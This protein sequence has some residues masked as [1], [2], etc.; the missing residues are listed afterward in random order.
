MERDAIE[1]TAH[2][3]II[4]DEITAIKLTGSVTRSTAGVVCMIDVLGDISALKKL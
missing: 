4:V 2:T 3:M 1:L